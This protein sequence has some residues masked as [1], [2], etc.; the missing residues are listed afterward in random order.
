SAWT[1]S[2]HLWAVGGWRKCWNFSTVCAARSKLAR[3]P[4]CQKTCN[5]ARQEIT[6]E[7]TRRLCSVGA[8]SIRFLVGM[9]GS[10]FLACGEQTSQRHGADYGIRSAAE[11]A[12]RD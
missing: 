9:A 1:H 8:S 2:R 7:R 5:E 10:N 12:G 6:E 4:T 11:Q 3:G